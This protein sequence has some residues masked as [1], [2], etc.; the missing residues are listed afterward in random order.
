MPPNI[1]LILTDQQRHDTLSALTNNF[2]AHTPAMDSLVNRGTSFTSA[3]CTSPICGPS[4]G[5]IMT[6][7]F[8]TQNGVYANLGNPCGPLNEA[9]DTLGHHMQRH[10]YE[11]AYRGKWHLGG[12]VGRYGFEY[13]EECSHDPTTVNLAARYWRD[14]DWLN[15]RRPFLHVVSLMNPHDVYFLEPGEIRPVE[16][17]RWPNQD[18]DLATKPWPQRRGPHAQPWPDERWEYYRQFYREK[19]EKV[20]ANIAELLDEL[21]CS[22]F[23]PNTFVILA[24]DHGDMAGEHGLPFKGPYLY[25]GVTRVPLVI[26]PPRHGMLGS[27]RCDDQWKDYQARTCDALVSLID[28]LPTAL[29]ISASANNANPAPDLP[30]MSLM[31]AV[32]GERFAGHDAVF[33]QWHKAG[34]LCT[35]ARMVRTARYKYTH[36][37]GVGEELYDLDNDPAEFV[38]LAH[39]RGED[40]HHREV[41]GSLR[42]RLVEHCRATGD[43]FFDLTP[44][45]PPAAFAPG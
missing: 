36:Y 18:D 24:S 42:D 16:L 33:A 5:S 45:D 15:R 37:I 14:R 22:G 11:T 27:S 38:N 23:A 31:P 29:D 43:G 8:P 34:E 6:G 4:R 10:G 21:T 3:Y 2:G 39:P 20:D 40:P 7:L 35:P 9:L 17:P 19:T 32:R 25:D 26:A 12:D 44:S 41:L 28:I 1:L 13:A 30:G